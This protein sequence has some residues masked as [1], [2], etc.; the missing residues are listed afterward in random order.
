MNVKKMMA[1]AALGMA[2]LLLALIVSIPAMA[3]ARVSRGED[4]V[5]FVSQRDGAAELYLLELNSGH[6]S[7]LTNTGRSHLAASISAGSAARTIVFAARAGSS[8]EIFSGTLGAAWRNRRPTLVGL[9]RLTVDTM[10]EVSPTVSGDGATIAFQ[11]GAGIELM[12]SIALDR[13]VV[14][15][16]TGEHQDFAPVLSPDGLQIAFVSNR[17]G[18]YEI[19][20]YGR[21]DNSLRK[22]TRGAAAHG[23]LSWSADAKQIAFTTTA[24]NSR[25]SGI[26]VAE[27]EQGSFRVLTDGNDFNASFS[28]RG[29]RMVFTSMRDGNA[30]L[31]LLNPGTGSVARLTNN[32][33]LDDGAVFV[34]EPVFPTRRTP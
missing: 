16:A 24:T 20:L 21:A 12:S 33:G 34:T 10:D 23:G 18:S 9:S 27:V 31:Y 3:Q 11:S 28:A 17:G 29:D 14:I 1:R 4:Y 25:L 15:P 13:R 5:V 26:A 19:W 8:Y 30:E 32:M 2:I 22:L 7:Q 6:V